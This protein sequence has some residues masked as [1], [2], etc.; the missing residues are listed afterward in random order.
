[1]AH[2]L[3]SILLV[4]A[5][6][7]AAPLATGAGKT[8]VVVDGVSL[9]VFTYK[10]E[11]Y[12]DGPLIV[13]F[14]GMLRNAD[15]YRD[16]AKGL[17]DRFGALIVAPLFDSKRFPNEAYQSGGLF[18]KKELQPKEQWTWSMVP[19]LVDQVRRREGRPKM[20]YYLIGHSAGGQFL[21]RLTGFV[22]TAA[23]RIVVANP[24]SHLFP[25]RDMPFPYGFGKLPDSLNGEAPLKR[26]L[27]QPM[28][29]YLGTAD[30]E[31]KNLP[32]GELAT[33]QGATRYQR[34]KNCFKFAQ[35]LAKEKG[36]AFNW[37]LV[38]A[39]DIGHDARAMFEHQ[40]CGAAM[41]GK[42]KEPQSGN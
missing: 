2:W 3:C 24:G 16:N 21:C 8:T 4:V 11:T 25:T 42:G 27:A 35:D 13:V 34:G 30:I 10:P 18:K 7:E 17:G 39:P 29:I 40:N 38:E 28:T 26:Y 20:P 9:E 12:K 14:H 23:Q 36:Y 37:R 33:K 41:F 1:M 6:R 15:T 5:Q 19:K 32:K 31:S 22:P